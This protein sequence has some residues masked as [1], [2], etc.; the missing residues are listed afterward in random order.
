[1]MP[2]KSEDRMKNQTTSQGAGYANNITTTAITDI[3]HKQLEHFVNQMPMFQPNP[4]DQENEDPN[5]PCPPEQANA[6]LTAD[7]IKD[8][9][10][11]MLK[12]FKPSRRGN[13]NRNSGNSNRNNAPLTSQG[14]NDDGDKITYCWTHGITTNLRHSGKNCTRQKEGHKADATLNNK[15]GGSTATCKPRN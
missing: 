3:V 9:M 7:Q 10:K 13:D 5:I 8:I 4:N 12:D 14:T 15:M 6:A 1:M 11:D 2:S